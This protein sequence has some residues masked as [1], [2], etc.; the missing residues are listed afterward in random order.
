MKKRTIWITSAAAAGVLALGGTAIAYAAT[1][2]FETDDRNG[3]SQGTERSDEL[4]GADLEQATDAALAETGGGEVVDAE[5]EDDRDVAYEVDVKLD[6][7]KYVEVSLDENF[8]VVTVED[9]DADDA[10]DDA[11]DRAPALSPPSFD[12]MADFDG[13]E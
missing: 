1:D 8:D 2:G 9:D 4:T 6:S 13:A 11:D 12:D 10:D 5:R 7:G 3:T